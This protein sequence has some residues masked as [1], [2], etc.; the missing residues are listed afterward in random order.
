[1]EE[2]SGFDQTCSNISRICHVPSSLYCLYESEYDRLLRSIDQKLQSN[3]SYN[4]SYY[5]EK[6]LSQT[7]TEINQNI[8]VHRFTKIQKLYVNLSL[9]S[10]KDGDDGAD[11]IH[12]MTQYFVFKNIIRK[13]SR[14][15]LRL[16]SIYDFDVDS[17]TIYDESGSK[18][19]DLKDYF[20]I[21]PTVRQFVV[22]GSLRDCTINIKWGVPMPVPNQH[23]EFLFSRIYNVEWIR[24]GAYKLPIGILP[25]VL[26]HKNNF[27]V[28][29]LEFACQVDFG[30]CYNQLAQYNSSKFI[31]FKCIKMSGI[32][33]FEHNLLKQCQQTLLSLHLY[34]RDINSLTNEIDLSQIVLVALKE[35]CL[36]GGSNSFFALQKAC[37]KWFTAPNLDILTLP[38]IATG[39]YCSTKSTEPEFGTILNV[40][41]MLDVMR[42]SVLRF[43][44]ILCRDVSAECGNQCMSLWLA[45]INDCLVGLDID[46]GRMV[47]DLRFDR[48]QHWDYKGYHL[49]KVCNILDTYDES[50]CCQSIEIKLKCVCTAKY[51]LWDMQNYYAQIGWKVVIGA[52]NWRYISHAKMKGEMH[53]FSKG[54]ACHQF[55]KNTCNQCA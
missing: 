29:R 37:N 21:F 10:P 43:S 26:D 54:P 41:Q 49:A 1:M 28:H 36:V 35:L 46:V 9:T 33:R 22:Y 38:A 42:L 6:C 12:P 55:A 20:P 24:Y 14:N 13:V 47:V 7:M 53:I 48:K 31:N 2:L 19:I 39:Y 27:N 40:L 17:S 15:P 34:L 16:L 52:D 5:N 45:D 11:P 30:E 4:K 23:F 51:N 25:Y 3:T 18:T 50:D 8:D 44:G 32:N